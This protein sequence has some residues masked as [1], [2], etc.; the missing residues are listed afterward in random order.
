MRPEAVP[1]RICLV[2]MTRLLQRAEASAA[3]R[4]FCAFC[5]K[6]AV[7]VRRDDGGSRQRVDGVLS[8]VV[9]ESVT[10]A[11]GAIVVGL[12]RSLLLTRFL[13]GLAPYREDGDPSSARCLRAP[14][15]LR[16]SARNDSARR[17]LEDE[18]TLTAR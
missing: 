1:F 2:A 17:F 12:V 7:W 14:A 3:F 9:R 5:V 8:T 18:I 16:C 10:L 13:E 11:A 15:H 6:N 4:A